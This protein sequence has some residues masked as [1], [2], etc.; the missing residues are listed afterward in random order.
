MAD[1]PAWASNPDLVRDA[2]PDPEGRWI[3]SPLNAIAVPRPEG[4]AK[5]VIIRDD[6]LRSGGNTPGVYASREKKLRIAEALEA[7]GVPE[8]EVGYGSLA[9]DRAFVAELRRRGTR[10]RLGMHARS[11]LPNWQQDVDGIAECGAHLVNFVGMQ[12]YTVQQA[13]HPDLKGDAFLARMEECITYAKSKGLL[14]AFGTDHPRL[15]IIDETL[16]RAIAAGLDRWVL[17]DTRGW[18]L[19]QTIALLVDHLRRVSQDKIEI[20]MHAHDD[21]GLATAN[22]LEAIRAGAVGCDVT[23]NRTGHRCGN[24]AF[25]QVVLGVEYFLGRPTGIDLARISAVSRLVS[26]LYEV[27]VAENAP[28]VGHNMFS[29]GGLHIPAILR[30]DWYLWENVRAET[31]GSER[32]I[33][34]GPSALQRGPDSPLD[35]KSARLGKSPSDAQMDRIIASLRELIADKKFATDAEVE[36]VISRVMG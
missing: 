33:V 12:G 34:Y 10:M 20:T 23:I 15:E 13:L 19:P 30:G 2:I 29:Y 5:P 27:P 32:H 4:T 35:A 1:L 6:T 31:V 9:D 25:E 17:Y 26:Q 36:Q 14:A 16:Q 3:R 24:A 8:A 28:V 21:F 7:M 22:T 18:F 11:W